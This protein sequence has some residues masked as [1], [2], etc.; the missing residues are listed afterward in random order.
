MLLAAAASTGAAAG[1]AVFGCTPMSDST[2]LTVAGVEFIAGAARRTAMSALGD[3]TA[4]VP[5]EVLEAW[6]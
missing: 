2:T 4:L 3:T 6:A 5:A 1:W